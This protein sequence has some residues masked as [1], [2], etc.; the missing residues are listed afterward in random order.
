MA[1]KQRVPTSPKKGSVS[2]PDR[3]KA[4]D[5]GE[6][7]AVLATED[8]GQPYTS[9]IAYAL[10]P[11]LTAVVFPTPRNTQKYRNIVKAK[12]VALLIDNRRKGGEDVM[13]A[14]AITIVGIARPIRRGKV[15]EEMA[16]IFL[17]KHPSLEE[18]VRAESTALVKV[19]ALRCIHVGEFQTVSV[20]ECTPK[21]EE[22]NP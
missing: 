18:F 15:W 9:L 21:K 19:E 22:R 3:L 17:N 2:V 12:K 13:E 10:T 16:D 20:W 6:R 8:D 4:F 14:E 7:F 11:N 5:R 1:A